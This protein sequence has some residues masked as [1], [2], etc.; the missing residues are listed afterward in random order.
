MVSGAAG[1][2]EAALAPSR[3]S[4]PRHAPHATRPPQVLNEIA[5]KAHAAHAHAGLE[6]D[7][8]V[9]RTHACPGRAVRAA[10]RRVAALQPALPGVLALCQR[11]GQRARAGGARALCVP[12]CEMN[13]VCVMNVCAC[14]CVLC[15][16]DMRH[17]FCKQ[18]W[19]WPGIQGMRNSFR[20]ESEKKKKIK[21][22][23]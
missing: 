23:N 9:P 19:P 12:A 2:G 20:F 6:R 14:V 11:A 5:L 10:R 3:T 18:S 4:K 1:M 7:R 8:C 22:L 15:A 13:C 21:S 16:C 17:T